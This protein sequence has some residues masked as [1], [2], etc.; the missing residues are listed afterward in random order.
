[1]SSKPQNKDKDMSSLKM[2]RLRYFIYLPLFYFIIL[3]VGVVFAEQ[4]VQSYMVS[5]PAQQNNNECI[6][7]ADSNFAFESNS[8]GG[9][10]YTNPNYIDISNEENNESS[11]EEFQ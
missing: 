4:Y 7:N 9:F 2:P 5:D 10:I 3:Y 11:N 8:E 1:M 6:L